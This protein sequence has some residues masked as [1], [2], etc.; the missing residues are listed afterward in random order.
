LVPAH[1]AA[2]HL[3]TDVSETHSAFVAAR[4]QSG[5]IAATDWLMLVAAVLHGI[6]GA[7]TIA[8]DYVRSP[9][10]RQAIRVVLAVVGVAMVTG[11]TWTL[12]VVLGRQ[13]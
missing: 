3:L 2:T 13:T 12:L 8:S 5:V 6:A 10:I 4:W 7:W 11:G 1:F 9:Q